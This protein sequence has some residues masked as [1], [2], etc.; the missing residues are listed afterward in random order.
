[1][2]KLFQWTVIFS[3]MIVFILCLLTP[4]KTNDGKYT[5]V[6]K[7]WT[8]NTYYN[9]NFVDELYIPLERSKDND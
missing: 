3:S 4:E 7:Y 9:I 2:S 6:I 5:N 8:D 1:M